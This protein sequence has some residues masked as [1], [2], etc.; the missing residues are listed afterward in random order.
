M[1][2]LN[3]LWENET[4][5]VWAC[6]NWKDG[7]SNKQGT[8]HLLKSADQLTKIYATSQQIKQLDRVCTYTVILLCRSV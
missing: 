8:E 5:V 6:S 2:H 3:S 1:I 7:S 4:F